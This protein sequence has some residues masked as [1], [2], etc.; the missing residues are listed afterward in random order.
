MTRLSVVHVA[1]SLAATGGAELRLVEEIEALADRFDH[2][3][4]RLYERD[5][6]QP[7]LERS[8]VPVTALGFSA[9]QAGRTWPL[10]AWRLRAVLAAQRPHVVHTSLFS[11][12]LVGQL[13]A[14]RLG[15]PVVSSFNRTG[16]IALQRAHQ[17]GVAGWRGRT[18][19]VVARRVA[20]HGD[21]RFRAVSAD[22]AVTNGALFE[23]P[24][25]RI[26][27]VPRG[28]AVDGVFA[29][30]RGSFGL[31]DAGPLFVNAA[32]VAPEK[33]Q[34]LLVEAFAATRR[35]LPA[36]H[37]AI[38]GAPGTAEPAVR[39]AIARHD[40]GTAVH[41]LGWRADVRSLVAAADV[42]AFSS[43]SEGWPSAV[44][45]AMAIG[46]P[47]VAFAIPPVV[48]VTGGY[49]RLVD[50]GDVEGLATAMIEAATT[51]RTAEVAEAQA[52]T[53][54]FALPAVAERLGDLLAASA[55]R[56]P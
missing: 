2:H 8:G 20:R 5:D 1:D 13:A 48:E 11:G 52:W 18:M 47:V 49:A 10:A 44:V 51:R 33:A 22:A 55:R 41:L 37:L 6:L 34:T 16:D 46:T 24:P 28:I 9:H 19:Q 45:E 39:D 7:R 29:A 3:V 50:V 53:E 4:V 42:F 25:E 27:V 30:D 12:N 26:T 56:A 15:I 17:P 14:R 23:V 36:A 40:L 21:V 31:P 35:H 32:R 43:L 54:Q 38:A